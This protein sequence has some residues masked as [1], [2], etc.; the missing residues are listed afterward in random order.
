MAKKQFI[1][2]RHVEAGVLKSC[3]GK[4]IDAHEQEAYHLSWNSM[5]QSFGLDVCRFRDDWTQS[6][7]RSPLC[8][9][10]GARMRRNVCMAVL[11]WAKAHP[12]QEMSVVEHMILSADQMVYLTLFDRRIS[13]IV[14]GR[15]REGSQTPAMINVCG[16]LTAVDRPT[17]LRTEDMKEVT[18]YWLH[19]RL[20]VLLHPPGVSPRRRYG[21]R[22]AIDVTM[23]AKTS[24]YRLPEIKADPALGKDWARN[25]SNTGALIVG[26]LLQSFPR[27]STIYRNDAPLID[28]LLHALDTGN[29]RFYRTRKIPGTDG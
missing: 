3:F 2:P 19:S 17:A 27:I 20:A 15:A 14:N 11:E 10:C 22:Q 6:G 18:R 4:V 7:C 25:P 21:S 1:P 5:R 8:P 24:H 29:R 28:E 12:G 26:R 9:R 13:T 16:Y 23:I